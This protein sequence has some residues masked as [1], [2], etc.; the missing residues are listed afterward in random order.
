MRL[1]AGA[2]F[3]YRGPRYLLP[4]TVSPPM[5]SGEIDLIIMFTQQNTESAAGR[6]KE[7]MNRFARFFM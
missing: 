4:L 3:I 7:A 6:R 1:L 5:Y 2:R